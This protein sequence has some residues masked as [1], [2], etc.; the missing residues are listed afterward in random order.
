MDLFKL[1]PGLAIWTWVTFG[2]LFFILWKYV[3]PPV[4]KNIKDREDVIARSIEN[5]AQIDK[6]VEEIEKEHSTMIASAKAE[7]DEIL[8]KA[9][10]DSEKVRKGLLEKA[11][12]EARKIV[13]AGQAAIAEEKA[14]MLEALRMDIADFVCDSS[15]KLI[16]KSFLSPADKAWTREL[17]ETL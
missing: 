11:R 13:E 4:L 8:R 17:V 9:R 10:E 5:A 1:D 2:A 6:R 15:E 7:A 12:A 14:V 3:L 16:G